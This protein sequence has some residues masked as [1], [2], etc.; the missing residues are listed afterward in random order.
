[1]MPG[2]GKP[3]KARRQTS[4]FKQPYPRNSSGAALVMDEVR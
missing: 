4:L 1:M 2:A 3:P